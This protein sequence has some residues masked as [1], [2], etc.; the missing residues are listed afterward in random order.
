MSADPHPF[1]GIDVVLIDG[2]NLL[3]RVAGGAGPGQLRG[4]LPSLRAAI[5][6]SIQV[7]VM[8]DGPSDPGATPRHLASPGIEFRHSGRIDADTALVRLLGAQ[9]FGERH[10]TVVVTDDRS[11]GDRTRRAGATPRRLDW[12]LRLLEA[13]SGTADSGRPVTRAPAPLRGPTMPVDR[14]AIGDE[15]DR[16]TDEDREDVAS[17]WRPGRGATKKRGNPRRRPRG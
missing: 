7:I 2:N 1:S 8:L 12:L 9:P 14:Q 6:R 5:P 4:L 16:Y 11:L 10:R 13:G 15:H 17:P 3:H